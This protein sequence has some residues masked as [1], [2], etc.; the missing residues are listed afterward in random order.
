MP[1]SPPPPYSLPPPIPSP[2]NNTASRNRRSFVAAQRQ[3][4]PLLS[5]R[6]SSAWNLK[7]PNTC[8]FVRAGI[9][10][11][12]LL[13]RAASA[14]H[15]VSESFGFLFRCL[16]PLFYILSLGLSGPALFPFLPFFVFFFSFFLY[17]PLSPPP[18]TPRLTNFTVALPSTS[19]VPIF[20]NLS[21]ANPSIHTLAHFLIIVKPSS[22][23]FYLGLSPPFFSPRC[24]FARA[25][26]DNISSGPLC[27]L[28]YE[29]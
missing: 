5:R 14:S 10:Q 17:S 23:I 15:S 21:T 22:L 19:P 2:W 20:T 12:G 16:L 26:L 6:L 29:T 7:P 24:L 27:G 18:Q 13:G 11:R 8:S 1:S 28:L 4:R 25:S 3:H 9:L